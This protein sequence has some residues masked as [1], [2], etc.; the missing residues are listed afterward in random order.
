MDV[1]TLLATVPRPGRLA[2][3]GLR[4]RRRGP[5]T[6]PALAEAV[7]GLGLLGD[8]RAERARPDPAGRR[9]VTLVQAEHLPVLATLLARDEPVDP[10]AL[11]RNLVVGGVNLH[12]LG[13]RRFTIGD[14]TFEATGPC[15]PCSRME[16]ELGPGG[17]QAMRGHGGITARVLTHGTIHLGDPV[18][19]CPPGDGP[20]GTAT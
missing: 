2:W 20:L 13:K 15:H 14:V 10:V 12:A 17:Y 16:E 4:T 19:L 8:R 1:R 5:M 6:T 11:R 3:I 9:Q 7:P 18:A